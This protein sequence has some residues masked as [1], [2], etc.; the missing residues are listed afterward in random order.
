MATIVCRFTY[1][2][3]SAVG[4]HW[5]NI[6]GSTVISIRTISATAFTRVLRTHGGMRRGKPRLGEG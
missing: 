1:I 3:P 4:E 6:M 2:E 5:Y